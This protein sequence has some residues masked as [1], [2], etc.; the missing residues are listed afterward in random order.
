MVEARVVE[1]VAM[2]DPVILCPYSV[3]EAIVADD[4]ADS[5]PVVFV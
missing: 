1:V 5:V 4:V 3:V 2:S